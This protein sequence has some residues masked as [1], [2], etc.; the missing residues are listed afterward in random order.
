MSTS[1]GI[2]RITKLPNLKMSSYN[3]EPGSERASAC[4]LIF[5]SRRHLVM[6]VATPFI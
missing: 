4:L 2:S 5:A 3:P 6:A 1:L